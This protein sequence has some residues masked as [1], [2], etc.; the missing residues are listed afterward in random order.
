M[1]SIIIIVSPTCGHT[2]YHTHILTMS[3]FASMHSRA[4]S[5]PTIIMWQLC[6][7]GLFMWSRHIDT[8]QFASV[9][10]CLQAENLLYKLEALQKH[11]HACLAQLALI[12]N[13]LHVHVLQQ[14]QSYSANIII[15]YTDT[16]TNRLNIF[17]LYFV[18]QIKTP[19]CSWWGETKT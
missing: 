16:Q 13:S 14:R 17:F 18:Q 19:T 8:L 11:W 5:L 6:G 2:P 1:H 15:Y 10:E 4:K 3:N 7:P 12:S 9:A